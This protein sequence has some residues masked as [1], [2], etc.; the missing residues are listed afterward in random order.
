MAA[1]TD[2]QIE[3]ARGAVTIRATAV[4]D[5]GPLRALRLEALT[6]SPTS[7]GSSVEEIDSHDWTALA[8]GGPNDACFVAEHAGALVGLAAIHRPARRKH[9]HHADVWRVYVQPA[10]RRL[11][12]AQH[13]V[14]ACVDWAARTG[15]AIVKLTVVPESGAMACYLRCGFHITGVDPA[16]LQWEGR[17]YDELLMCRWISRD[18]PPR[19]Q[20]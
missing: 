15:V 5:A 9:A 11:G 19:Q 1:T 17:Y 4:E 6:G 16:A 3:T 12:L 7:F 18:A 10:W 14:N 20:A 2:L 8:T 13:L